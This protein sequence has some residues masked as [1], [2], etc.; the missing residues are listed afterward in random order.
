MKVFWSK[1]TFITK[2]KWFNRSSQRDINKLFEDIKIP[3]YNTIEI[4][5]VKF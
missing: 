1:N 4:I 3:H 2:D 5:G